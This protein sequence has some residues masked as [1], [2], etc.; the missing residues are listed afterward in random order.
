MNTAI[1]VIK[2]VGSLVVSIGVGSVA[3]NIIKAT[4]P[5][6]AKAFAKICIGVGSFFI[7]GV[8]SGMASD[9]FEDTVDKVGD[10]IKKWTSKDEPQEEVI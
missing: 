6:N 7:A 9:K 2:T 1:T 10:I 8:A 3:A 4:T 5:G